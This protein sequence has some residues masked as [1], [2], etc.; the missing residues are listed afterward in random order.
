[1]FKNLG[2]IKYKVKEDVFEIDANSLKNGINYLEN[3]IIFKNKSNIN[4]YDRICNHNGGRLISN[5]D[6][7]I[8]I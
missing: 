8:W 6:R 3:F 7:T 2:K 4:I 5:K 1:M